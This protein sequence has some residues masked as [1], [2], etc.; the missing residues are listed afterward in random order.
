MKKYIDKENKVLLNFDIVFI[1]LQIIVLID[2]EASIF[3]YLDFCYLLSIFEYLEFCYLLLFIIIFIYSIYIVIKSIIKKDYK[4]LLIPICNIFM[5]LTIVLLFL[6]SVKE[7][8][9]K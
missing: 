2:S 4:Y 8:I 6:F 3:E 1:I 7:T 9:V 5:L